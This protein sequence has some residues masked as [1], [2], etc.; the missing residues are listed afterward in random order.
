M[1]GEIVLG[2][3]HRGDVALEADVVVVGSGA[4]GAVAA[5]ELSEA[6]KRVVVLEEGPYVP[7]ERYRHMR[8]TE[9]MR[10]V[11][12]D[13]G[14]TLAAGV[15]DSPTINV[16]MGR[17]VGGSSMLTGGVCF[18]TPARV[19]GNWSTNLGLTEVTVAALEPC[20]EA[21]ERAIHVETVPESL[22]SRS[23]QLFGE[24]ARKLG[25]DL[26]S[27]KRNTID[28]K[29][30]GRCNFG[31]PEGAKRSVD[32]TYLPR[33]VETGTRLWSDCLVER[34]DLDGAR[35]TGVTAR[36]LGERTAFGRRKGG[37]LRVRAATVVIAAGSYH[38]PLLLTRSGIAR[39]RREVG[40]NMTLHPAFRMFARFEE[41]VRGWRGALQSAYVDAHEARGI[42]LVGLFIPPGVL[43]AT[44]HGFG[45]ALD[46]RARQVS[47]IGVF[48]G[49]VHDEGGGVVR[50][51]PG[52]EPFVTYRMARRN[53]ATVPEL[54][55]VM[56]ET[57]FAAGAR[58]I[59]PP[60]LGQSGVDADAFRRLDLEHVPAM[61]LECSSQHPLGSCR[62]GASAD[63]SVVDPH[64]RV[65]GLRNVYVADG[66]VIPTSLGVNPQLTIMAM[67][68]RIAWGVRDRGG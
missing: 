61:R 50:P 38:S 13:G 31:C 60:I 66:S 59:F 26:V 54:I 27:L 24:G 7:L 47:E 18:R 17:C 52:R 41:P 3:E 49:F 1:K 57:F 11:W 9:H 62:M 19:L 36:L 42:T 25:H 58:E 44:M 4:G 32:L 34:I 6:G 29:G 15:G 28:C 14:M 53:R 40:R 51:G 30:C 22:R 65:W 16:T 21:V 67:A 33:A 48:G 55:R 2:A 46:A 35:A 56:A 63:L 5:A 43:A 64:G 39:R 12:R 8:V 23:T 45:P 68:T 20:F 37:T 10:T